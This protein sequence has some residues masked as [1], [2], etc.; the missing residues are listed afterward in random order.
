MY[1]RL[2]LYGLIII[3]AY[4][5]LQHP[6]ASF[7]YNKYSSG[8]SIVIFFIIVFLGTYFYMKL[9]FK[10]QL[11]EPISR[12]PVEF[13][14]PKGY[15]IIEMGWLYNASGKRIYTAALIEMWDQG[16]IN[17]DQENNIEV[18]IL[19]LTS[20][21]YQRSLLQY[22]FAEED[23]KLGMKINFTYKNNN[24]YKSQAFFGKQL[25]ILR[26]DFFV[27]TKLRKDN[28]GTKKKT[29]TMIMVIFAAW[30]F[31]RISL[32]INIFFGIFL[33]GLFFLGLRQ[34]YRVLYNGVLTKKGYILYDKLISYREYIEAIG[35]E[36]FSS[37]PFKE[38][39]PNTYDDLA[40]AI[41][42]G[43]EGRWVDNIYP[44]FI[45]N[46]SKT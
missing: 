12:T 33:A 7:V 19:K 16:L 30:L 34:I 21:R 8:I 38:L 46:K 3:G 11:R 5:L 35:E 37:A 29:I 20:N 32:A 1:K 40:Y 17:I 15:S 23:L 36:R 9:R 13:G 2:S 10:K 22:F 45:P 14:S 4:L 31:I 26:K 39:R 27:S 43:V 28:L 42:F 25:S 41:L 24:F 44:K 6:L 18:T